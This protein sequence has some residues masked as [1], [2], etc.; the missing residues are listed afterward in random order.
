MLKRESVPLA[1]LS[2]HVF[3]VAHRCTCPVVPINRR[4][5]LKPLAC[6]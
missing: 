4:F 2:Q 1:A 5:S 3:Q 6:A